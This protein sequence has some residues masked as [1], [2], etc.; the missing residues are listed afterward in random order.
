MCCYCTRSSQDPDDILRHMINHH[1]YELFNIRCLKFD[2]TI[3][4]FAYESK[5]FK[6]STKSLADKKQLGC[7]ILIDTDSKKIGVKRPVDDNENETTSGELATPDRNQSDS[8]DK[9]ASGDTIDIQSILPF[10]PKVVELM[11]SVGCMTI[12]L[13]CLRQYGIRI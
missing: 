8:T 3:G 7:T 2:E 4:C 11:Q 9:P 6:V 10:M 13:Q 1:Q 12:L 5:H